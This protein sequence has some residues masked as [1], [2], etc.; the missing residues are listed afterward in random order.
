MILI[1]QL[2]N[3]IMMRIDDV[4]GPQIEIDDDVGDGDKHAGAY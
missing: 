1:L 3:Q 2:N 4:E